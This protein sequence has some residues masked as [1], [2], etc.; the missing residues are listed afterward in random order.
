MADLGVMLHGLRLR[1]ESH[2]ADLIER[3][4]AETEWEYATAL[5]TPAGDLWDHEIEDEA[6]ARFHF[7]QC[8]TGKHDGDHDPDVCV[9]VRRRKAIEAGPWELVSDV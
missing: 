9:L 3:L 7:E 2:A 1:G 8:A 5:H 4:I 6:S